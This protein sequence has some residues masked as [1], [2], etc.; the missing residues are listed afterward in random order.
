MSTGTS[1][2]PPIAK[3]LPIAKNGS[4]IKTVSR[5]PAPAYPRL[6]TARLVATARRARVRLAL[7][8]RPA[9]PPRLRE[10]H[11]PGVPLRGPRL[12]TRASPQ[13]KARI[14]N[15]QARVRI[16]NLQARVR[17][18]NL[19]ARVRI[20]NLQARARIA[21][22]QARL[23][24]VHRRLTLAVPRVR[25]PPLHRKEALLAA[26][27]PPKLAHPALA[28]QRAGAAAEVA[29]VDGASSPSP[30]KVMQQFN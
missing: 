9:R 19:Q 15:L 7:R 1:V 4:P 14:V 28:A 17:I 22:L 25:D 2:T 20:V 5:I 13:A 30:N 3:T 26:A 24:I 29:A 10:P 27:M 23:R 11:P 6:R 8:P 21:N 16:V 18:V 12:Q